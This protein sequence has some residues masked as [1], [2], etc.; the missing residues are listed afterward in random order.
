M[1]V[2]EGR[3]FERHDYQPG[4]DRT[5]VFRFST[6]FPI[7]KQGRVWYTCRNVSRL[8]SNLLR[9]KRCVRRPANSPDGRMRPRKRDPALG[10]CLLGTETP[11]KVGRT[12][13]VYFW[14]PFSDVLY[15]QQCPSRSEKPPV[16][17]YEKL[18]FCLSSLSSLFVSSRSAFDSGSQPLFPPYFEQHFL[19]EAGE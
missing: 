17:G 7:Q 14:G 4:G 3:V 19:P 10:R 12:Y 6:C 16:A 15:L 9:L 11:L 13:C 18:W 5:S 2:P 8:Q 1:G